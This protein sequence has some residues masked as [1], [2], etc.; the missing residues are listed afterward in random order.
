LT[1]SS[2]AFDVNFLSP[3]VRIWVV[4]LPWWVSDV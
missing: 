2:E 1:R 4:V 3:L